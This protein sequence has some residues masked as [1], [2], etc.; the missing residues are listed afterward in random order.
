MNRTAVLIIVGM[1]LVTYIPRML[2]A[3]FVEKIKFGPKTEKFLNLIPYTAMAALV[4]P[5]IFGVDSEHF[6]IGILGGGVAALLA[7]RKMPIIVCV[8]A[9]ISSNFLVY[10]FILS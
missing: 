8:L 6:W 5:G 7:W 4:F 3:V 9:A 1:A 2:P 10:T